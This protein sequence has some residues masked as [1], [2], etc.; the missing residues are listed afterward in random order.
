MDE[1]T[2]RLEVEYSLKYTYFQYPYTKPLS[3]ENVTTPPSV[4]F[5]RTSNVHKNGFNIFIKIKNTKIKNLI[6]SKNFLIF[7]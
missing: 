6:N 3:T 2:C 4:V 7:I 1:E 5:V